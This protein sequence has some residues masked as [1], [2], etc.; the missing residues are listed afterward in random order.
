MQVYKIHKQPC[1]AC[2]RSPK[3]RPFNIKSIK[4]FFLFYKNYA[5]GTGN[6]HLEYSLN[7]VSITLITQPIMGWMPV[8]AST[9]IYHKLLPKS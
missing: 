9:V 1:G 8:L 7:L 5:G 2:R 6:I 3:F 4:M